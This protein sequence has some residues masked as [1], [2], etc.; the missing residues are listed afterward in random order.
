MHDLLAKSD[1]TRAENATLVVQRYA[2]TELDVFRFLY[3][4]FEEA[5]FGG[6]LVDAEFL[7]E[8]CAR[9]IADGTIERMIDEQKLHHALAALLRQRRIGSDS[10]AFAHIL[11][12]GNL[13]TRHP[14]DHGLSV[15]AEFRFAIRPHFRQA[16][17][18]QAHTAVAGRA[19]LF[20]IAI[21]RDVTAGLFAGLDHARPLWKLMPDAIDLDVH[22]LRRSQNLLVHLDRP[23]GGRLFPT[24]I[25]RQRSR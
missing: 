22:Q 3:L 9:L 14:I 17:F 20:V 21:T 6:A 2:G 8:A 7:E 1:A 18:D 10:H 25:T 15:G 11:R 5:R 16:H 13:R 23:R 4:V 24:G 19:E 12:A